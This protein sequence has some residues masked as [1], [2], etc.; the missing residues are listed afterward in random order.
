MAKEDIIFFDNL[1]CGWAVDASVVRR[2]TSEQMPDESVS[3]RCLFD[4]V[5]QNKDLR[6]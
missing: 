1:G 2:L 6:G 3:E 4:H 5:Y